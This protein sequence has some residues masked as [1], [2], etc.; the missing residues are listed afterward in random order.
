MNSTK[1]YLDMIAAAAQVVEKRLEGRKPRIAIILG[2]GLGS[3][4]EQVEEATAI[5]YTDIPGFPRSTV[6]GHKGRFLAGR[7]GGVEVLC[8]QGRFHYYEGYDLSL[9]TLP[10]RVMK[11]LGI[12]TLMVTNAAGGINT[13]FSAGDLMLITDHINLT[14][15]NPLIGENLG[16]FGPRFHDM[17]YGYDR[18]HQDAAREVAKAR[19]LALKEGV[20]AWVTGPNY[21]T[22]AEIRYMRTIGADAVGMSTVP[23]VLVARH[24][25]LRVVGVS[26]ITNMAAGVTQTTLSH[27][28]VGETADQVKGAFEGFVIDLMKRL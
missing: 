6:P 7:L 23:E 1:E 26:C 10:I 3:L 11:R 16:D 8:M 5:P 25:G 13:A 24:C 27:E 17:T 19:G 20:Y 12:E 2:S 21:E 28:E 18:A 14:G 9:V 4:G 22:P 15:E